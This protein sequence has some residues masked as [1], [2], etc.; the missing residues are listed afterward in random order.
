M[1]VSE[2]SD[3]DAKIAKASGWIVEGVQFLPY[4]Y[5]QVCDSAGAADLFMQIMY[6]LWI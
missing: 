1:F 4:M 5:V 2:S 6:F 3:C